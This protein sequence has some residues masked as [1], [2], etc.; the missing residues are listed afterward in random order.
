[1]RSSCQKRLEKLTK[2]LIIKVRFCQTLNVSNTTEVILILLS[3]E[4]NIK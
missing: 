2:I 1:M 4:Y 3:F